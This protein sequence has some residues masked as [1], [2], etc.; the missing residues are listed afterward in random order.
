MGTAEALL[1]A[2]WRVDWRA[3]CWPWGHSLEAYE[4]MQVRTIETIEQIG[5]ILGVRFGKTWRCGDVCVSGDER[6]ARVK[7]L[8]KFVGLLLSISCG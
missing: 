2:E 3:S 8:G 1:A 5:G 4:V 7:S 6:E